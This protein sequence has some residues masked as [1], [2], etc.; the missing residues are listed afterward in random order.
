MRARGLTVTFLRIVAINSDGRVPGLDRT[1]TTPAY[2]TPISQPL[3]LPQ[4]AGPVIAFPTETANTGT[5]PAKPLTNRQ[6]LKAAL[7]ACHRNH[8]HLKRHACERAARKRY[9]P[10]VSR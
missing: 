4:I 9:G 3:T 10:R 7:K 5:G 2:N 6:K 8:N 1:F